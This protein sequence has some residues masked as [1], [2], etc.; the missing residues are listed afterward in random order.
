MR[1][2]VQLFRTEN[3]PTPSGPSQSFLSH[4]YALLDDG[5]IVNV[6][7]NACG[8]EI[9]NELRVKD[10]FNLLKEFKNFDEYRGES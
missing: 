7:I 3:M 9:F 1:K 5:S 2:I 6:W 4:Q 8:I 10:R